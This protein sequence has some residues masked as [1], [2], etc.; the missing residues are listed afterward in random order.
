MNTSGIKLKFF[1]RV[2]ENKM[3]TCH[4]KLHVDMTMESQRLSATLHGKVIACISARIRVLKPVRFCS[5]SK[6]L[7]NIYGTLGRTCTFSKTYL[8]QLSKKDII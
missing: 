5:H 8:Y 2:Q 7:I 1:L 4:Q 6:A 3:K